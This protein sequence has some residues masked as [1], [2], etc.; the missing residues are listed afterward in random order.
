[1]DPLP[2]WGRLCGRNYAFLGACRFR[3]KKALKAQPDPISSLAPIIEENVFQ[4]VFSIGSCFAKTC[5]LPVRNAAADSGLLRRLLKVPPDQAV[6]DDRQSH[7][8]GCE[9]T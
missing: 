4:S 6:R 7:F 2:D 9:Q 1:M 5:F 8:G 3:G